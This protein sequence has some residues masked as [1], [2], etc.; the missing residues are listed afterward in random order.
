[1]EYA[2]SMWRSL[3]RTKKNRTIE[4]LLGIQ[5]RDDRI[6][7]AGKQEKGVKQETAPVEV[8]WDKYTV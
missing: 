1:M 6:V 8:D 2:N 7:I 3:C 4:D 5:V